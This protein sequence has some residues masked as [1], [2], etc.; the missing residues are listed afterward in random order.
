[1][2]TGHQT[3]DRPSTQ[4]DVVDRLEEEIV[5]GLRFPRERLVEDDLMGRFGTKRHVVRGALQEL[6][7]RGLVERTPNVGA[8]VKVYTAKDVRDVYAVRELLE[9]HCA[10]VIQLPVEQ[11]RIDEL[12]SIQRRHDAAVAAVD[13]RAV[14]YANMAFHQTLFALSDNNALV[15]AI[16]RHAQMTYAIRSVTV[17]SPE[18]LHRAQQEHWQMIHALEDQDTELLAE[19]ARA[20]LLPSRDAYLQR[21]A[22][23]SQP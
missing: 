4:S 18:F 9:V 23:T 22:A 15:E 6:E 21:I 11:V 8:F 16:R 14:V 13:L 17:T 19:T 10:K 2:S 20:H 7:N 1:M 12:I 3:M 5:L